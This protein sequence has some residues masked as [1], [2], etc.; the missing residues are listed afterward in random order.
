MKKYVNN[1][2]MIFYFFPIRLFYFN[3]DYSN[4][5][6]QKTIMKDFNIIKQLGKGA[7][8]SVFLVRR[9]EDNNIYALKRVTID[10]LN[11]KELDNSLNE[12]RILASIKHVNII[13]YKEAFF[14]EQTKTL[15]IVMEYA[16]DGDLNSKITKGRNA[17]Y[18]FPENL[19]WSYAIQMVRG[20]KALHDCSIMHRDLKSANVFLMKNGI[21]KLGDL[22]V[23]KV[24]K[25][26]LL[27]TQTGTPYYA[28]PEVWNDRPYSYKSD[29]WSIGVIVYEL[30]A[31]CPPFRGMNMDDLYKNV[32]KG[33]YTEI[34]RKIY[35]KDLADMVRMLLQ[36]DAKKRPSCEEFLESELVKKHMDSAN[37]GA[38]KGEGEEN[39]MNLM[40][41]IKVKDIREIKMKLPKLKNYDDI[42]INLKEKNGEDLNGTEEKKN[43]NNYHSVA[44]INVKHYKIV[45]N[46]KK[47]EPQTANKKE[48]KRIL[49]AKVHQNHHIE[50]KGNSNQ[51]MVNENKKYNS[52]PIPSK[53]KMY[54]INKEKKEIK[55]NN[56]NKIKQRPKSVKVEHRLIQS[57]NKKVNNII[58]NKPPI[59]N[60]SSKKK[61]TEYSNNI[62]NHYKPSR[63]LTSKNKNV[64]SQPIK[65]RPLSSTPKQNIIKKEQPIEF[66][67]KP[68][69]NNEP[70]RK[71]LM[72][73][74]RIKDPSS[75]K[76]PNTKT[77]QNI[78]Y[79]LKKNTPSNVNYCDQ[80]LLV[81]NNSKENQMLQNKL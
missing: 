23:S 44:G 78:N 57:S 62:N 41:S 52:N 67:N 53:Y 34:N 65:K 7:F 33:K 18:F 6:I 30:C 50:I 77:N 79:F 76:S 17:K 74:I 59:N 71:I 15:N 69:I 64:K 1:I 29:L 5:I 43:Q 35:S 60:S 25:M 49:S 36:V 55:T 19:I 32:C 72:N 54:Q 46:K 42:N 58:I 63:P 45:Q 68:K 39:M 26:G 4:K 21:C 12:V 61:A 47:D 81:V 66:N 3:L 80:H 48:N 40:K 10:K 16:D 75:K 37:D 2:Y 38:I 31:L 20:L 13:G 8:A 22:N 28:S 9:K 51:K 24:V 14:D 27:R 70:E 73:P 11:K 56:S